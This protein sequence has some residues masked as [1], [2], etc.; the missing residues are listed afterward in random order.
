ML[1]YA[2]VFR[3]HYKW[4]F[5][6]R[7]QLNGVGK[8]TQQ[9]TWEDRTD[10]GLGHCSDC[11]STRQGLQHYFGAKCSYPARS[12]LPGCLV[13]WTQ[14]IMSREDSTLEAVA[15]L[16]CACCSPCDTQLLQPGG[17][18]SLHRVKAQV[19]SLPLPTNSI[20]IYLILRPSSNL[21]V[22]CCLA[23]LKILP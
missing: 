14:P 15:W 11:S 8:E 21:L 7:P 22:I 23:S 2:K 4:M 20:K 17:C 16:Q 3:L 13:T 6:I 1:P 18:W 5:S 12:Q 10:P 19:L 9:V